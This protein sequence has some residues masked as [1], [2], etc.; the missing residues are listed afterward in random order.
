MLY[1]TGVGP[2]AGDETGPQPQ[3]N[4]TVV[5]LVVEIGGKPTRILYRGRTVFPGLDQIN[6]VVPDDV[7][8]G[9]GVSVATTSGTMVG[10]FTTIPV[11]AAGSN[12]PTE[13]RDEGLLITDAEFE[14]R[15]AAGQFSTGTVWLTRSTS[16]L[17]PVGLGGGLT[18][19]TRSDTASARF[20]RLSGNVGVL[21]RPTRLVL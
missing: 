14:R 9:C 16:Y 19:L 3:T 18:G 8:F 12:C 5:P 21:L 6:V 10:N 15:S 2:T 13:G 20:S 7:G 1:G 17:F 4:L 11:A